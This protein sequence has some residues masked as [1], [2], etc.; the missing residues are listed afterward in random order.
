MIYQL[1]RSKKPIFTA[2]L[3]LNCNKQRNLRQISLLQQKIVYFILLLYTSKCPFPLSSEI[4]IITFWFTTIQWKTQENTKVQILLF[5]A[6]RLHSGVLTDCFWTFTYPCGNLRI[7][8]I[9][10]QG[11]GSHCTDRLYQ[12]LRLYATQAK[13]IM[14]EQIL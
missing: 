7:C 13:I 2:E 8:G 11:F 12:G 14:K 6:S 10:E 9:P 1:F 4:A 5:I 3:R